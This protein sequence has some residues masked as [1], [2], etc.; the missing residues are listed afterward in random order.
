MNSIYYQVSASDE[1]VILF[2]HREHPA[3][4]TLVK[5]QKKEIYNLWSL[6]SEEWGCCG[7]SLKVLM[8]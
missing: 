8:T 2:I 1:I 5:D 3:F 7:V 6:I 4:S